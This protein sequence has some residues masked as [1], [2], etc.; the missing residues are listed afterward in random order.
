MGA[1][2]FDHARFPD[3][4]AYFERIFSRL[5]FNAA[6]WAQVHCPFHTPDQ[7]ES[8]S[9]HRNGGFKCFACPAHGGDILEFEHLFSRRDRRAIAQSWGAWSGMPIYEHHKPAWARPAP[10]PVIVKEPAEKPRPTPGFFEA[11]RLNFR[12][13]VAAAYELWGL[14]F[15]VH[16]LDGKFPRGN[17]WQN[18]LRLTRDDI[19]WRF[20]PQLFNGVMSHPNIGVRL[21]LEPIGS[22]PNIVTDVD[23]RTD[24]QAEIAACM[25][26]VRRHMG[27]RQPD[28]I[29]GRNGLHFYDQVSL[30]HLVRIF[31]VKNDGSLAK[32][33]HKL[34]WPGRDDGVAYDNTL[35]WTIELFGPKHNIVCPPSIHPLTL[36]PY[37]AAR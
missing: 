11:T 31:G 24:D 25:S 14:G 29:T 22:A 26:A 27:D 4:V 18:R 17:G 13:I 5:R 1:T 16:A 36:K 6:G 10:R 37:R 2:H 9:L 12:A 28:A 30:D 23:I 34:D 15:S 3:P 8:L 7:E 35:P 19:E 21:D 33:V 20:Q 32:N